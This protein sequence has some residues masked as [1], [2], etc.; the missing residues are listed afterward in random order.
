MNTVEEM[1]KKLAAVLAFGAA[2]MSGAAFADTIENGFGNTFVVTGADGQVARYH[3]NEDGTF[4]GVAPGGSTMAGRWTVADGQVCL[5]PPSGQQACAPV[6]SGKNV[7]D[8]WTQVGTDGTEIT[9][10][11]EAGR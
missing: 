7:G 10:T 9:I 6:V 4:T 8:T 3:F 1:M 11:L 5:I 2:L